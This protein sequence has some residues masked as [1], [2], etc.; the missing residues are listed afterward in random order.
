MACFILYARFSNKIKF[1]KKKIVARGYTKWRRE[2]RGNPLPDFN[3]KNVK[4]NMVYA[5]FDRFIVMVDEKC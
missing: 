2:S 1:W 4:I 3:A 5:L